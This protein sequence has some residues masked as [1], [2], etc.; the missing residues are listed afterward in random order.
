[1]G[2]GVS[3]SEVETKADVKTKPRFSRLPKREARDGLLSRPPACPSRSLA[4]GFHGARWSQCR[5]G[6]SRPSAC[7][8]MRDFMDHVHSAFDEAT[9]WS[10]DN[11]YAALNATSDGASPGRDDALPSGAT[12]R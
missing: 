10:R 12:G 3:I 5:D 2:S 1:M 7:A 6:R 4:S 9:G 11:S 8:E